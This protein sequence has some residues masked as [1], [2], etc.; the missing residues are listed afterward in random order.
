M[1]IWE[2]IVGKSG[3][4]EVVFKD[5][6]GSVHCTFISEPKNKKQ[7]RAVKVSMK[8]NA[9]DLYKQTV[10]E[11]KKQDRAVYMDLEGMS[12]EELKEIL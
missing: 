12:P 10:K 7:L 3:T 9:T 2:R 11:L 8:G 1:P 6:N 4:S 5:K